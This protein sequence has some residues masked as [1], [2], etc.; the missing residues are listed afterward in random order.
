[1]AGQPNQYLVRCAALR[2]IR[3]QLLDGSPA[4]T[5]LG[6]EMLADVA[7][8]LAGLAAGYVI[9]I[10]GGTAKT[11]CETLDFEIG[12]ANALAA[13]EVPR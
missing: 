11:A 3:A 10:S 1:M 13:L 8:Y 4:D 12:L 5:E 2:F 6:P 9:Y 7:A